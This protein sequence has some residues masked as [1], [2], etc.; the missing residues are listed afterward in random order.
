MQYP[1]ANFHTHTTFCDGSDTPQAVAD[2]AYA[3]GFTALGFSGHMDPDIHMDLP[4]YLKEIHRLQ[5]EYTGRMEILCGVEL[6]TL[7][8]PQ[9]AAGAQYMIGSTHFLDVDS[10]I[11]LSV[12]NTPE[13]MKLLA[14]EYFGG[15]YYRLAKAYYETE[16]KV[17]ERT[18]CTFI[19]HF[20]LVVR[21]NDQLHF[22]DENDPRYLTP[23]LETMEYLVSKGIPFEINCGAYNRGRKKELYP[24]TVLLKKLKELGGEILISSDSHQKEPLDGGFDFAVQKAL[25]CGFTH[26]N[27]LTIDRCGQ[28]EWRQIA[29]DQT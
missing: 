7:Y 19:G 6:D 26:T 8:D 3:K 15:D 27:L 21:F 22:L 17:A 28:T 2:Y 23:A 20:D 29:L 9:L 25:E 16:A 11:P 1:K 4:A 5:Q 24:N 14:E 13:M 12:D 18:N 10:P